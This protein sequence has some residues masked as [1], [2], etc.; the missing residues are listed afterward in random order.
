MALQLK[1]NQILKITATADVTFEN[2]EV[3][4]VMFSTINIDPINK[5]RVLAKGDFVTLNAGEIGYMVCD[6]HDTYLADSGEDLAGYTVENV[7]L[8]DV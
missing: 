3:F 4:T 8:G 6:V 7:N 5:R 2:T 1:K